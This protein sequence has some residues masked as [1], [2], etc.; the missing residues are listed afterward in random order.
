MRQS[1]TMKWLCRE[2]R[3]DLLR[4]LIEKNVLQPRPV[5]LNVRT[6]ELYGEQG[7]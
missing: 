1:L 4:G 5:S 7:A 3:R 2:S 6:I